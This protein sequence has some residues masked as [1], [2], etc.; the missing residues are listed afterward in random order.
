MQPTWKYIA[1]CRLMKPLQLILIQEA[2]PEARAH[3]QEYNEHLILVVYIHGIENSK[4]LIAML[5]VTIM[6]SISNSL[7]TY[8]YN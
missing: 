2:S 3:E 8:L 5:C 7:I 1:L 4:L 6:G